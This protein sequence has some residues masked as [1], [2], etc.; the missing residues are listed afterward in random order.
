MILGIYLRKLFRKV[1]IEPEIDFTPLPVSVLIPVH[2][3]EEHITDLIKALEEQDYNPDLIEIIFIDDESTDQTATKIKYFAALSP[4]NIKYLYSKRE[5]GKSSKK[6]AIT[7][8]VQ[9]A[10][11]ELII[12]I[13]ADVRMKKNWISSVVFEWN[14]E[15]VDFL[16]GLVTINYWERE[17][18]F[19]R[20][21]ALDFVGLVSIGLALFAM[22]NPFLCNA[23]NLAF[24]KSAFLEIN[25]YEGYEHLISGD[26]VFLLEKMKKHNKLIGYN[27]LRA[28]LVVTRPK[29]TFKSF[30]QQRARWGSKNFQYTNFT[31]VLFQLPFYL[32]YPFFYLLLFFGGPAYIIIWF[33]LKSFADALLVKPFLNRYDPDRFLLRSLFS[34]EL[35]QLVYIPLVGLFMFLGRMDWQ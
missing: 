15:K 22:K 30:L 9:E 35:F 34:T 1:D 27:L 17:N 23:A 28:S 33:I 19:A 3:E 5:R 7:K 18:F 24:R 4:L 16:P 10:Q 29:K 8:G 26:D 32:Y 21:Q 20:L 25:G 2:N 11:N 12:L 6:I 14:R 13:D 31:F